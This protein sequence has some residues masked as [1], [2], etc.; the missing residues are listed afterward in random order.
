MINIENRCL[1]L[2]KHAANENASDIHFKPKKKFVEI[3]FRIYGR[4]YLFEQ[5][6]ETLYNRMLSH[7]K[8]QANMDIGEKRKPQN[9]SLALSINN[10]ALNIRLSTLPTPYSES[11]VLR[12]LPQDNHLSFEELFLF[13]NS[14]KPL[15]TYIQQEQGLIILTGPTGSGKTTTIYA[16]LAHAAHVLEKRVLTIE[17]PIEKLTDSFV[18]MEVNQKA[19]IT[20]YEGFKAILRHDPDIIFIGEIRDAETAKIV[21]EAALSGHMIVSTMHAKNTL[22]AIHRLLEFNI[23]LADLQQTMTAIVTQKLVNLVCMQ[24]QDDCN[25]DSHPKKR[26]ALIEMLAEKNLEDALHAI[27]HHEKPRLSISTLEH[28]FKKAIKQGYVKGD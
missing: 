28:E 8:F 15:L 27:K 14:A 12:L 24:C 10:K 3:H 4:T 5:I 26:L 18:Q 1:T 13:P 23:P 16:L 19:G 7:F 25:I 21:I 9:G 22:G 6:S 20:F 11:L 17:D 2:L